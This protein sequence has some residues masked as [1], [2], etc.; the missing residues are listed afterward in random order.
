[1]HPVRKISSHI[2]I[3]IVST[4]LGAVGW[5]CK[6]GNVATAHKQ[7]AG[8]DADKRRKD[9]KH[10]ELSIPDAAKLPVQKSLVKEARTWI[11]TPY[12]WGGQDK[13]GADCSG[14]VM[15]VFRQAVGVKLPRN[16]RQQQKY[17]TPIRPEE[18]AVGD[19][20]FFS[21]AKSSGQVAHVGMYI[22]DNKMIHSSS[23]KGVIETDLSQ[24]YYV[25]YFYGAGRVPLIA[26]AIP[27]KGAPK[28][29]EAPEKQPGERNLA[30][31]TAADK[32]STTPTVEHAPVHVV[33]VEV[34][35]LAAVLN[36]PSSP[37]TSDA[38]NGDKVAAPPVVSD[39]NNVDKPAN[40]TVAP[41]TVTGNAPSPYSDPET[42][43]ANAFAG[44]KK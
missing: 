35:N 17:C 36:V 9:P 3:L 26:Q 43:V 14:F 23:S 29:T 37:G 33:E 20:V 44:R 13:N 24:N 12:Q 30:Q 2:I 22:G 32:P 40:A 8:K 16:S 6:T 41:T 27:V 28:P 38:P 11:G 4:L 25:R 19:L 31:T 5:S 7:H 1:M 42:I 34:S 18:L 21:S 39:R 10:E 15:E